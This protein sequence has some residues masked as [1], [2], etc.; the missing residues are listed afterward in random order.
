MFQ[1]GKLYRHK[2][3]LDIDF[4]VLKQIRQDR[5]LI[6]YFNRQYKIFQGSPEEVNLIPS[7][8]W[9]EV[10]DDVPRLG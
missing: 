10:K 5:Y 1:A 9:S 7:E 6:A 8:A 4:Y 3:T 2:N